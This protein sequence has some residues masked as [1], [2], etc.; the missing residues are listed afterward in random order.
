MLF[1]S[2]KLHIL[3]LFIPLVYLFILIAYFVCTDVLLLLTG[4]ESTVLHYLS[5]E[6]VSSE[7]A[8]CLYSFQYRAICLVHKNIPRGYTKSV[9][10][11]EGAYVLTYCLYWLMAGG[12]QELWIQCMCKPEVKTRVI[13]VKGLNCIILLVRKKIAISLR[14]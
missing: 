6:L 14:C 10:P 13:T 12:V 4:M 7:N 1:T 9:F 11:I 2:S 8:C 3:Y 5:W